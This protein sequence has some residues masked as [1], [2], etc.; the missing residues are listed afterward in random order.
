MNDNIEIV[1]NVCGIPKGQPRPKAFSRGGH[2]RVYDPGTA[3][4]WKGLVALAARP[5]KDDPASGPMPMLGPL[6]VTMAFR[7]PRPAAHFG[8]RGGAPYLKDGAPLWHTSTPDADN[9]AKA[10][11]D[12]LT[13]LGFWRDDAQVA[14]LKVSKVY[15]DLSGVMIAITPLGQAQPT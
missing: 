10:V 7:M 1:I 12:A 8:R 11:M 13:Q 2:A 14:V 6:K 15:S 9:L 3:E 4:G 5:A